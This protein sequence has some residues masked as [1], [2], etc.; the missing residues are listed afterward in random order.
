MTGRQVRSVA[1]AL[2]ALCLT[3]QAA[4]QEFAN[5]AELLARG[6]KR[7]SAIELQALLPGATLSG[8]VLHAT[9]RLE[10]EVTYASDGRMDGKLFGLHPSASPAVQG[11]WAIDADGRLCTHVITMAVGQSKTCVLFYR[12]EDVHFVA[13]SDADSA[14]VRSRKIAR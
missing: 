8:R 3:P 14:I 1:L 11:T 4:A 6:A 13:S 2:I 9:S 12:L 7:L 10:L 5:L